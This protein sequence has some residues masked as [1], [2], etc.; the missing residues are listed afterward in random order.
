[1]P[2]HYTRSWNF[3]YYALDTHRVWSLLA[4]WLPVPSSHTVDAQRLNKWLVESDHHAPGHTSQRFALH[5][6]A[7]QLGDLEG[8]K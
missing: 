4:A 7:D 2:V 8:E 1:V 3:E 5:D 6:T